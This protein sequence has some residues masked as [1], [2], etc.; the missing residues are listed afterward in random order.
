MAGLAGGRNGK[1]GGGGGGR[2][3]LAFQFSPQTCGNL[4]LPDRPA[5]GVAAS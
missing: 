5:E 3:P 1:G 2:Q 4:V